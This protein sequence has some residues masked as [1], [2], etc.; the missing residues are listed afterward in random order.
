MPSIALVLDRFD[1]LGGGLERWVH[2]LARYL[3][4]AGYEVHIVTFDFREPVDSDLVL[5]HLPKSSSRITRAEAV[6]KF[7]KQLRVDIVHDMGVGW[8][9]DILQP[10]AGSKLANYYRDLQS[11][12]PW[13]R[14]RRQLSPAHFKWYRELRELERRQ[15]RSD[16]GFFIAISKMVQFQ[17][18]RYHNID[19]SRVRIVYN[20]VDLSQFPSKHRRTYRDQIRKNLGLEQEVLF[21]F[22]GNNFRLKGLRTALKAMRFFK[23]DHRDA[24]LAIVGKGPIELYRNIVKRLRVGELVTFCGFIENPTPYYMA[25]DVLIHPTFYDAC[26][27]VVLEAW[28]SGLPVI[29]TRFNGAGELMTPGIHGFLMENP[30]DDEALAM[31]MRSLL[32]DSLRFTMAKESYAL[33]LNQSKEKNYQGI[34]RVYK[35]IS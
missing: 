26:S 17:L 9:F 23:R 18:Q 31:K 35:E 33:G 8:S 19:S 25:A 4:Q 27:L 30:N 22:V 3:V 15:Y 21:L 16:K 7:L 6:E 14:L 24:H 34:E 5:H 2:Q 13:E 11:Q 12:S 32:D 20:G 1:S 28:A 29:T 10:H